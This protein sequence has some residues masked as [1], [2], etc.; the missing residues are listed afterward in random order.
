LFRVKSGVAIPSRQARPSTRSRLEKIATHR[1][2]TPEHLDLGDIRQ[3]PELF[4]PRFD[5]I[6]F[7]PGRSEAHITALVQALQREEAL[8]P[9]KVVAFGNEW[10]LIDGHHRSEAYRTAG[11]T[12][13]VPVSV[14]HSEANGRDRVQWAIA[15]SCAENKKSHLSMSAEDKLDAA[16]RACV[17]DPDQ[18]IS[19]S[20][21]AT[22]YGVSIASVGNMRATLR[23]LLEA[24]ERSEA[25][26]AMG[27]RKAKSLASARKGEG[28]S[29]D[30]DEAKARQLAMKLKPVMDTRPSAPELANALESFRPG[31]VEL[32]ASAWRLDDL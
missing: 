20:K 7:A 8:D 12:N 14:E 5:S 26:E 16:W 30:W 4:Q 27:W 6:A 13:R 23:T 21:T 9:L 19:K 11:R 32:M 17:L 2:D 15:L 28:G 3:A 24:G 10:F 29:A 31:I 25:L 1:E 18:T 22:A